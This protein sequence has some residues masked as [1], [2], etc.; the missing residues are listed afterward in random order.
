MAG[1]VFGN[2]QKIYKQVILQHLAKTDVDLE[3]LTRGTRN[4][5]KIFDIS[6]ED[7]DAAR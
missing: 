1:S 4:L 5:Y 7:Y 6:D 3:Y 2:G